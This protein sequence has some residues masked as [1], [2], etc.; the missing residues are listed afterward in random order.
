MIKKFLLHFNKLSKPISNSIQFAPNYLPLSVRLKSNIT[1][2][3]NKSWEKSIFPYEIRFVIQTSFNNL[4]LP[5]IQKTT[6]NIL[7]STQ[8]NSLVCSLFDTQ[9]PINFPSKKILNF[10]KKLQLLSIWNKL[11]IPAQPF[12]YIHQNLNFFNTTSK[13]NEWD[14]LFELSDTISSTFIVFKPSYIN[15]FKISKKVELDTFSY[16]KSSFFDFLTGQNIRITL[17]NE[18]LINKKTLNSEILSFG[19]NIFAELTNPKILLNIYYYNLLNFYNQLT[20]SQLSLIKIQNILLISILNKYTINQIYLPSVYFE[21]IIKKM[22]SCVEIIES[23]NSCFFSGD[24][25]DFFKINTLNKA[26]QICGY[27]TILYKPILL[28]LTKSILVNNTF[29]SSLSFQTTLKIL[30]KA[31]LELK[32]DWLTDLK[33]NIIVS[34]LL[35][36]GSGWL[37]HFN[38]II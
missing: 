32:T 38:K 18:Y 8:Y 4:K 6:Q 17:T 37:R 11:T 27:S 24:L 31:A 23:S 12:N 35:P 10:P 34:D 7:F 9:F 21:L 30:G 19:T 13:T 25:I 16:Q 36:M 14:K 28:G 3:T 15:N 29:L 33:S 5:I 26:R 2:T 20:S 22:C 1:T